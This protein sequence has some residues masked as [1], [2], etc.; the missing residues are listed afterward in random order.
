MKDIGKRY[1]VSEGCKTLLTSNIQPLAESIKRRN[2]EIKR[3]FLFK[4]LILKQS[5]FTIYH[6]NNIGSIGI[7][8]SYIV[9]TGG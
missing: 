5:L 3:A 2:E 1:A 7:N 6:F 9:Y 4:K 8:I